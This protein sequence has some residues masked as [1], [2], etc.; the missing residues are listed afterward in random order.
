MNIL[1]LVA[2]TNVPSNSDCFADAFISGMQKS[3][4]ITLEKIYVR[5]LNLDH[6]TLEHYKPETVQG[7]GYER[8]KAAVLKADAVVFS[9]PIW[10]FSVPAHL[11]NMIDRMGAFGLD[12]ETR[13]K[14]T[15]NGKPFFFL[16][17]GGAPTAA[18]KGLMRFTTLHVREGIRYFGGSIAG[19]HFA[20]KCVAGRGKF[21]CVIA[22]RTDVM[23]D[24]SR[25]GE[26]FRRYVDHYKATGKLPWKTRMAATLYFY[27]QRMMA[28]L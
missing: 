27:G 6:F 25:R 26:G 20:G 22:E 11:K 19:T 21:G 23:D 13:S 2:G 17:T 16:F 10:N 8:L 14:G 12:T 28:K 5:D 9:T 3:G 18:W 15:L 4:P 7:A 1:L 24:A